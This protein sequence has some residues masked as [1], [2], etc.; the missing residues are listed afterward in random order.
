MP[1][2]RSIYTGQKDYNFKRRIG[3]WL[4]CYRVYYWVKINSSIIYYEYNVTTYESNV[5]LSHLV[6]NLCNATSVTFEFLSTY[7][8]IFF[9]I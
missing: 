8:G 9:L 7:G 6:I 1:F 2:E 5:F 3:K 4:R